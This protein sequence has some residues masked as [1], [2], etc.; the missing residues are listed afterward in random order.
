VKAHDVYN[1]FGV[2]GLSAMSAQNHDVEVVTFSRNDGWPLTEGFN[3]PEDE[4]GLATRDALVDPVST[5]PGARRLILSK[6]VLHVAEEVDG[7]FRG[8]YDAPICA[9]NSEYDPAAELLEYGTYF[10]KSLNLC[11]DCVTELV[12]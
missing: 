10:G 3:W 4:Y 5:Y 9:L 6:G 7:G 2:D 12:R 11:P 1:E 8:H